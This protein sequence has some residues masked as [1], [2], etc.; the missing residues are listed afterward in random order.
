MSLNYSGLLEPQKEH[1][2]KLLNSLHLNGVAFDSSQTGTGKTYVASWIAKNFNAPV[3]VICPKVVKSA[4]DTVLTLFGIKAEVVINYEKLTR[5]NTPHYKYNVK[6]YNKATNW[7]ESK[8]ITVNFPKNALVVVDECHKC[9]GLTSLNGEMLT[10]LKTSGYNVLVL[11][12]TAATNVTEMK[13]FGYLM[14]LHGGSNF[15]NFCT[16][17]G[18]TYN[19]YGAM[20]WDS[21]LANCQM[22]LSNIHD[23]LYNVVNLASRMTRD[24]FGNIFADNRISADAFDMGSNT[25]KI[26]LVYEQMQDELDNLDERSKNYKEH[27]FAIMMKAR[28]KTELFKVPTMV[29][30]IEDMFDEGISPVVFINF[31][32][33]L[34]AIEKRITKLKKFDGMIARVV[35]GQSEKQRNTDVDAFQSDKKRVMLVNM[36]AG[37][38]GLGLHDLNG[39]YPRMSLINSNWSAF[40]LVQSLGRIHRA[41]GKTPC[42]QKLLFAAGT[43]ED[44]QRQRVD[45]KIKN[46]DLL[47]DGDLSFDINLY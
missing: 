5:G 4:W 19:Q 16:K 15:R 7:W 28:R 34:A 36:A 37:N 27:H 21:S 40:Q 45:T 26:N 30:W 1:A 11:S 31:Q 20:V 35:G 12:A 17:N 8:G 14:N 2:I 6:E 10:V 38:L 24:M 3:V 47:N 32:D 13:S 33:T 44:R 41:G 46:I 18:V 29:D 39:K 9:K 22:G 42:I 25:E 43:I 23:T